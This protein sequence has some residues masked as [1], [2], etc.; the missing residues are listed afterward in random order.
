MK[1]GLMLEKEEII[2][3]KNIIG[4]TITEFENEKDIKNAENIL[5]AI[6][7]VMKIATFDKEIK[8]DK[9]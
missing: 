7:K 1:Y 2:M 9:S 3:I 6:D 5:A 4:Y 8:N